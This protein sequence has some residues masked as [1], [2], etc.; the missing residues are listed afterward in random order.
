MVVD[1]RGFKSC[2]DTLSKFFEFTISTINKIEI[3][4]RKYIFKY[5][6]TKK[7][8]TQSPLWTHKIIFYYA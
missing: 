7:R 6:A 3:E 1:E 4:A 2:M 5:R 8:I